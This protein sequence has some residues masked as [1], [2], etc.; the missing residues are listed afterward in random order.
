M[1][2]RFGPRHAAPMGHPFHQICRY[3]FLLFLHCIILSSPLQASA[4]NETDT[5]SAIERGDERDTL[6]GRHTSPG[7]RHSHRAHASG[8]PPPIGDILELPTALVIDHGFISDP[9]ELRPR[10][11]HAFIDSASQ[12]YLP[13]L[14]GRAFVRI[15]FVA[16]VSGMVTSKRIGTP[17][18]FVTS[19][20]PVDWEPYHSSN[21]QFAMTANAS[22][23]WLDIRARTPLAPLR[24]VFN[25]SFA[26]PAPGFGFHPNHA[27]AQ[28]GG[29][30]FGFTDSAFMDPD[31]TPFTLDFEGP[32][33]IAYAKHAV[34]AY[35]FSLVRRTNARL[36]LTISIEQPLAS[37][38]A[39][40]GY[41]DRFF[42]PDGI[43]ALRFESRFG[44]LQLAGIARGLGLQSAAGR[45]NFYAFAY[46]GALTGSLRLWRGANLVAGIVGGNGIGVY[47]NDL[48]NFDTDAFIDA[49]ENLSPLPV[50]SAYGGLTVHWTQILRSTLSYGYVI[51]DDRS[52]QRELGGDGFRRS[53]Y[54]AINLVCKPTK[55]I[56]FGIEGLF[57]ERRTVDGRDGQAFRGQAT[58]AFSY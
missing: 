28:F 15:G 18:W 38:R 26:Q 24:L 36:N 8:R 27:Y 56:T 48:G 16:V 14:G 58:F 34:L 11:E 35:T 53:H 3:A 10:A 52:H 32:N 13:I 19:A 1:I 33:A 22:S 21:A 6:P 29:L 23:I 7:G 20:I 30:L 45:D 50:M 44:H 40:I 39:P 17:T 12:N 25:T 42:T 31:A 57:G 5:N 4:Q 41:E 2:A 47:I 37:A 46:G 9:Q 54:A 51:L 55:N 49:K 43:L